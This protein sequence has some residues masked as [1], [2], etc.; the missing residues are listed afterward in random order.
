M[1]TK[2]DPLNPWASHKPSL[3]KRFATW[4]V[5]GLM[6]ILLMTSL[7][8]GARLNNSH[9]VLPLSTAHA[10]TLSASAASAPASAAS[11]P[12]VDEVVDK[13][14]PTEHVIKRSDTLI[15]I[16]KQY[17]KDWKELCLE[18][19]LEDCHDIRPGQKLSLVVSD[20]TLA[21]MNKVGKRFFVPKDRYQLVDC[22]KTK[23]GYCVFNRPGGDPVCKKSDQIAVLARDLEIPKETAKKWTTAAKKRK[24]IKAGTFIDGLSFGHGY[25]KGRVLVKQDMWANVGEIDGKW[26]GQFELCCNFFP[27]TPPPVQ[28][29]PSAE[30]PAPALPAPPASAPPPDVPA[31]APPATVEPTPVTKAPKPK[32]MCDH[33]DPAVSVGQEY[34]L[35]HDDGA[36]DDSTF[37]TASVYCLV[38]MPNDKGSH[39]L[40]AKI[41]ASMWDGNTSGD[42][43][44]FSGWN[45]LLGPSYKQILDI[46][47]DWE[48]SIVGG[49]QVEKYQEGAYASKR[50]FDLAGLTAGLNDYRRRVNGEEW[51]PEWQVFGALTFPLGKDVSH[52]YFG[53]PIADTGDLS[54]F[55]FG[56]QAGF[57][58]WIYE[59]PDAW[60]HPYFQ[61]GIFV[62]HPTSAS[63]SLRAGIA[64]PN[65]IV[66][67]GAGVN[68][69]L[70]EDCKDFVPAVGW[71][72]DPVKGGRV[73]RDGVR[74]RQIVS[75]AAERGVTMD[76]AKNGFIKSIDIGPP[77]LK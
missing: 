52:S 38:R 72:A 29:L 27:M 12:I 33:I 70:K 36:K 21:R 5:V 47:V 15:K 77:P 31:S 28:E 22:S 56:L 73:V 63:M 55:N 59:S 26:V 68:C 48:V 37:G 61:A 44:Q 40:G 3:G 54:R 35:S 75:E 2:F 14:E 18:N 41:T 39:G 7:I 43:G 32:D 19:K 67:F 53:K 58:Q 42:R 10:A 66:G 50:E 71:W 57:R 45:V 46:G 24:L 9:R 4:V 11:G 69:D 64:D 51:F 6:L 65:H 8:W 34:T 76:R 62:Q 16:A 60:V 49:K 74:Q 30:P 23:L 13:E 17:G 20:A 1:T 25:W